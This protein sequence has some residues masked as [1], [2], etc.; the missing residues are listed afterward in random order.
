ML[1]QY[2]L[3]SQDSLNFFKPFLLSNHPL[4]NFTSRI[5]HNFGYTPGTKAISFTISRGNVWLPFVESYLP[6]IEED[7]AIMSQYIWHHRPWEF[8]NRDI[9]NYN[10]RAIM[11]DGIFSNYFLSFNSPLNGNLEI[12]S[13]IRFTSLTGGKIPVSLLTSD[14]FIEWFHSNIAGGEDAFGRKEQLYGLAHLYY[15]DT[16]NNYLTVKNGDFLVSEISNYFNYYLPN[17]C[18]GIHFN[19]SGLTAT[20]KI[21]KTW[22]FDMGLSGSATKKFHFKKNWLDWGLS[23]GLLLPSVFQKQTVIINNN[24]RLFSAESHW[25]YVFNKEK[26]QW[27]LGLN[28]HMQSSYHSMQE[29]DYNVIMRR[30]LTSH[31]HMGISH[32]NRWLQGWAFVFGRNWNRWTVNC[33]ARED[34]WVDNAPDAQVGWGIQYRL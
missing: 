7:R 20:S 4:G 12:K 28:F 23:A 13:N 18:K 33:F 17:S 14:E 27:V 15:N 16:E 3:F 21:N 19:F 31:D 9:T 24:N 10:S 1:F 8:E 30:G 25:N 2:G 26:G 6:N 32:L 34:F 5:N 22:Y 11:A 29:L